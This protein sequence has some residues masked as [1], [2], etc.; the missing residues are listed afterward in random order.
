MAD[1][2]IRN[3]EGYTAMKTSGAYQSI[4][5]TIQKESSAIN[6]TAQT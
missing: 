1:I 5:L 6:R 3:C 2:K 4:A